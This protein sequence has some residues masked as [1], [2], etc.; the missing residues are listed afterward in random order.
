MSQEEQSQKQGKNRS[1]VKG[2]IKTLRF[3]LT[4]EN[5]SVTAQLLHQQAP[6]TCDVIAAAL[7]H[8]GEAIHGK[9]SG[10]EV[11]TFLPGKVHAPAENRTTRVKQRDIGFLRFKGGT[12][13]VPDDKVMSEIA[14]F[15]GDEAIPSMQDGPIEVNV[16]ARF[17]ETG[18]EEFAEACRN[19]KPGQA[20]P[21]VIEQYD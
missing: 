8:Y 9:Y 15:Y 12:D 2:L 11:L 20:R 17:D 7:P 14:W 3:R 18:W 1:D 21:L 13:L 6:H 10:P 16:F 5:I 19:M 4:D